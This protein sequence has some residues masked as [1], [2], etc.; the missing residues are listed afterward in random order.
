MRIY[1]VFRNSDM[2]E[3]RGPMVFDSAFIKKENANN[4]VDTKPGVMG[5]KVKWSEERYGDWVVEESET[6]D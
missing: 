5:R 1:L 3:G 4:Y 6:K 2:T